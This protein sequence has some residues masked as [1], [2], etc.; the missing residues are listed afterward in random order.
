[1][2]RCRNLECRGPVDVDGPADCP[3]CAGAAATIVDRIIAGTLPRFTSREAP[4]GSATPMLVDEDG[5]S[6]AACGRPAVREHVAYIDYPDPPSE[7]GVDL[8]FHHLCHEIWKR[9]AAFVVSVEDRFTTTRTPG[10]LLT[11]AGASN[12]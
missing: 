10:R 8:H 5:I 3:P 9:E 2:A 7:R 4:D 11:Q 6:C 1:M 12:G